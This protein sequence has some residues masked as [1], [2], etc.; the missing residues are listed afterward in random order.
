[1][2]TSHLRRFQVSDPPTG[3]AH[4]SWMSSLFSRR[5]M[6]RGELR[7]KEWRERE[8]RRKGKEEP[9]K[10]DPEERDGERG[11]REGGGGRGVYSVR[12][13][14]WGGGEREREQNIY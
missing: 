14:F 1:M 8:K 13:F 3:C 12:Y 6:M 9:R 5:R 7:V 10:K 2:A 11:G 4:P